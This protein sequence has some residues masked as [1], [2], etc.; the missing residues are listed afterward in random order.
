M[1]LGALVAIPVGGGLAVAVLGAAT[2]G[3]DR[4]W[5]AC[6]LATQSLALLGAIRVARALDRHDWMFAAWSLTGLSFAIPV[7]WRVAVGT[8]GL[9][10]ARP[11]SVGIGLAVLL[12]V[13]LA[14]VSGALVFVLAFTRAGLALPQERG[15]AVLEMG[16]VLAIALALGGPTLVGLVRAAEAPADV[17]EA[18]L[19][20]A[21]DVACF[22]LVAPLWR[23]SRAFSGG[24]LAWPWAFLAFCNLGYLVFDAALVAGRVGGSGAP[25]RIAGEA[26]YAASTLAA[27][28]AALAHRSAIAATRSA[29]AA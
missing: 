19:V 6:Q 7:A 16:L 12:A 28:S 27:C 25:L 1:R 24:V 22:A 23:I 14:A 13:N 15:A 3:G 5:L 17:F 29:P 26:I 20:V 8:A 9:W 21:G 4:V 2:G 18:W 11:P 10:S